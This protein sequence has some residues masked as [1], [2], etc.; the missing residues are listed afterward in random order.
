[1][2]LAENLRE[3]RILRA[4]G[5]VRFLAY[6]GGRLPLADESVDRVICFDAFH[7]VRDQAH[8]LSEFARVLR[9]GGRLAMMEPGPNHSRTSK[10]QSEMARF[11]VIEN[12]VVMTE[13]FEVGN[14]LGFSPPQ[15]LVQFQVPLTVPLDTFEQWAAPTEL[16]LHAERQLLSA[17][18]GGLTDSQC[19]FMTKGDAPPDSRQAQALAAHISLLSAQ[20]VQAGSEVFELHF[21]I[22]NTGEAT[23]LTEPDRLGQ[24]KLGSQLFCSDG[25]VR[26]LD[27]GR[28]PLDIETVQPGATIDLVVQVQRPAQAGDYLCFDMVA[29]MIAWFEH[30]G[31]CQP[32]EW[33]PPA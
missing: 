9:P 17:L 22:Q 10:S 32:L 7:H 25:T 2:A 1:V 30:A 11:K 24:V 14:R 23:W 27:H 31:R 33:R 16:P 26:N 3:R 28:F 5:S 12:D 19:F 6:A 20:P 15:M 13:I 29:E 21:R 4:G 18:R 8:V